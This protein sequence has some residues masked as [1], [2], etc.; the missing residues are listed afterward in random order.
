MFESTY[1][2]T[3]V[4]FRLLVTQTLCLQ[5]SFATLQFLY[6]F[7]YKRI[8]FFSFCLSSSLH[9]KTCPIFRNYNERTTIESLEKINITI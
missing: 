7:K 4:C 9:R 8:V 1:A 5:N 6:R 2:L 3:N